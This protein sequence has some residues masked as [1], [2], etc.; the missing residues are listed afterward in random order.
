RR[1]QIRECAQA[2]ETILSALDV[3]R[4]HFVGCAFGGHVGVTLAVERPTLLESLVVF[5]APMQPVTGPDRI[6]LAVLVALYGLLGPK[7]FIVDAAVEA[8]LHPALVPQH[9]HYIR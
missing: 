8:L 1:F 7:D 4:P 9:G 6:K 5:N 3:E 2:A